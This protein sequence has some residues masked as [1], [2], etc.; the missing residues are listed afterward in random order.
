[1]LKLSYITLNF[2]HKWVISNWKASSILMA[3]SETLSIAI[4]R[5]RSFRLH[6]K[7]SDTGLQS[8]S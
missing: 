3:K 2:M 1:M 6:G 7:I 8:E 4:D 5:V